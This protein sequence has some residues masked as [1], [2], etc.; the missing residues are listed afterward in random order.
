MSRTYDYRIPYTDGSSAHI[1]VTKDEST[2][3]VT[4]I[5]TT[6]LSNGKA[7]QTVKIS[8]TKQQYEI[9]KEEHTTLEQDIDRRQTVNIM[10]GT[11]NFSDDEVIE[12]TNRIHAS[13]EDFLEAMFM[14]TGSSGNSTGSSGGTSSGSSNNSGSSDDSSS[15]SSSGSDSNSG[16]SG[17]SDDDDDDDDDSS[18]SDDS[19]SGNS[20]GTDDSDDGTSPKDENAT[21]CENED[22]PTLTEEQINA[23]LSI[24]GTAG[25]DMINYGPDGGGEKKEITLTAEEIAALLDNIHGQRINYGPD[26]KKI[27]QK[28][29]TMEELQEAFAKIIG[30]H[31]NASL[32][33]V[34][35]AYSL[36]L[37]L[38]P[39]R[40]GR[41][42]AATTLSGATS[43]SK[44]KVQA[45]RNTKLTF[46]LEPMLLTKAAMI[47]AK[48][49]AAEMAK[50]L[51]AIERMANKAVVSNIRKPILSVGSKT[52]LTGSKT[53][54]RLGTLGIKD[55]TI[56]TRL[57]K[58]VK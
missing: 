44:A 17:S 54:D 58:T 7:G 34:N 9:A 47:S 3:V 2:G 41:V 36:G 32:A 53:V 23:M 15:G 20:T 52:D 19:S 5:V 18:S 25:D 56:P 29:P 13:N 24:Y 10:I 43:L 51:A 48:I 26:G 55:P 38:A 12:R 6:T 39:T 49:P 37:K 16:N 28:L 27:I 4:E 22:T 42:G 30:Q 46:K 35:A 57:N 33:E 40:I 8:Y 11:S 21:G 31:M 14:P 1:Y 50:T 45:L